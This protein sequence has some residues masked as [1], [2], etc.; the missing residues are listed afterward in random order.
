[1]RNT[2][3]YGQLT[4]STVARPNTKHRG[5]DPFSDV[6]LGQTGA[7]STRQGNNNAAYSDDPYGERRSDE[8]EED[9]M[10]QQQVRCP[11]CCNESG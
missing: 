6:E 9:E 11:A 10:E 8:V 7:K 1:M 3:S 2:I 5:S 4:N